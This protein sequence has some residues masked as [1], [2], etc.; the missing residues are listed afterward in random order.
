MTSQLLARSDGDAKQWHIADATYGVAVG[1]AADAF[2]LRDG[3]R[4]KEALF[5]SLRQS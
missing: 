2:E 3:H 4:L 1:K 5:G